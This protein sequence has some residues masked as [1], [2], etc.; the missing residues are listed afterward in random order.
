MEKY[1]WIVYEENHGE[2]SYFDSEES[3]TEEVSKIAKDIAKDPV[4]AIVKEGDCI[5]AVLED[6]DLGIYEDLVYAIKTELNK[7]WVN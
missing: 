2:V 6:D 3:A 1:I 7:S 5:Y 4:K